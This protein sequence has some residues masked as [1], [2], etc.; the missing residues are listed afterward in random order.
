MVEFERETWTDFQGY[1]L[2]LPIY[3]TF[4]LIYNAG[5]GIL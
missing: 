3:V 5:G 2:L 1:I 4:I